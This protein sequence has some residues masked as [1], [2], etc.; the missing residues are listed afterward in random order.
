MRNRW[1]ALLFSFL[2]SGLG[3]AYAGRFR[4]GLVFFVLSP[5]VTVLAL[6]IAMAMRSV[7]VLLVAFALGFGFALFVFADAWRLARSAP[8]PSGR[9]DRWYV[10]LAVGILWVL[11]A[12]DYKELLRSHV[13]YAFRTASTSMEPT[14]FEGDWILALPRREP[15]RRG[16]IVTYDRDGTTMMHRAVAVAGDTVAMRNDTLFIGGKPVAE[17]YA[18]AAT[19]NDTYDEFAWQKAALIGV[20]TAVYQP[21][22]RN[23]GPLVVPPGRLFILGDHRGW[24]LDSRYIG[25]VSDSAVRLYPTFVYFSWD[26]PASSVR[27]ERIGRELR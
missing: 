17:P 21:T 26:G 7:A 16:Q 13:G 20:D 10:Y 4:R 12:P 6:A 9:F 22:M 27:W 23:W 11:I 25:F 24:S 15:P 1:L 5:A 18:R 3:Q 2:M 19:T 8:P 14:I